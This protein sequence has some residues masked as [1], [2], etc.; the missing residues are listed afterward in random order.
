MKNDEF[1]NPA[2][3]FGFFCG[4]I[5]VLLMVYYTGWTGR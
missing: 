4:A 3:L 1:F 5:F 2:L